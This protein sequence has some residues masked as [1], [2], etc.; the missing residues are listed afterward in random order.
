LTE[1][2]VARLDRVVEF[3]MVKLSDTAK[4]LCYARDIWMSVLVYRSFPIFNGEDL[5]S[6]IWLTATNNRSGGPRKPL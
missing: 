1:P 3:V 5:R 2:V 4:S 6:Y